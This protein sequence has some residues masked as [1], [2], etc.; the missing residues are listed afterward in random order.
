MV[1]KPRTEKGG[2]WQ[3]RN[4]QLNMRVFAFLKNKGNQFQRIQFAK[5]V[6][7]CFSWVWLA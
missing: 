6:D 3:G 7:R 5:T 1:S 2:D 4:A